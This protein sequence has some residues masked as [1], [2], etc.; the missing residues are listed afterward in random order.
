MPVAMRVSGFENRRQLCDG[1]ITSGNV[2]GNNQETPGIYPA[3]A[4][5]REPA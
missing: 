1:G 3:Q 4:A 2:T 5:E